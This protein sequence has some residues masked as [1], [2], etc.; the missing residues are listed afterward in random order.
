MEKTI[1]VG[2]KPMKMKASALIPKLYRYHFGRDIIQDLK[3]LSDAA[4]KN[5]RDG[6]EFGVPD[7]TIFEDVAWLF[8]KHGG[9]DVGENV[10]EWLDGIDGIFSIYE[11]L[12]QI[13][14]LWQMNLSQTAIPKKK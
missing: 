6:T 8:L 7:L 12:P 10:D 3:K 2:G 14:E 1:T 11:A 9:E 5:K 13:L 4:E